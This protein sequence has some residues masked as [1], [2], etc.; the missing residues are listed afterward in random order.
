MHPDTNPTPPGALDRVLDGLDRRCADALA[1]EVDVLVRTR[2]I[3]SR[4][5]AA[6]ALLDYRNGKPTTERSDRIVALERELETAKRELTA[7]RRALEAR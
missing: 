6:D 3:D 1:D 2:I 4:S 7:A 5:P